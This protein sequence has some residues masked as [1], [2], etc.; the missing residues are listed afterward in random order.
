MPQL[1]PE[2]QAVDD[3]DGLVALTLICGSCFFVRLHGLTGAKKKTSSTW[4]LMGATV[5]PVD[6]QNPVRAASSF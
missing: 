1:D 5:P 2:T 4:D 3:E 6:R